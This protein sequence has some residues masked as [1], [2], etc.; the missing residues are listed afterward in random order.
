MVVGVSVLCVKA[1]RDNR[2][3]KSAEEE[4]DEAEKQAFQAIPEKIAERKQ[5]E[6]AKS[7]IDLEQRARAVAELVESSQTALQTSSLF[8][9]YSKQIGEYQT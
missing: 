7:Q 2:Q 8:N 5:Q 4:V 1:I 6:L 9:L 3:L